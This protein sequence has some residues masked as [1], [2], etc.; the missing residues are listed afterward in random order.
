MSVGSFH[1]LQTLPT[2][3]AGAGRLSGAWIAVTAED[4]VLRTRLHDLAASLGAN[5]FDLADAAKPLYHAAAAAA[6]NFPLVALA[7]A[8]DLFAAAGVPFEAS[9]PLVDAVVANAFAL[10]PRAALTGPVARGDVGTVEAQIQAVVSSAPDWETAFRA[11]VGE[12]AKVTGRVDQ[13]RGI[14]DPETR[15]WN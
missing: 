5:P 8:A 3:E 14:V 12:L 15:P 10:G 13:F 6:A 1:P 11:L 2:P 9:K 7:M 4:E